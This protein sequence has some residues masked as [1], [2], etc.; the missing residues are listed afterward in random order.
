MA[1]PPPPPPLDNMFPQYSLGIEGLP[2]INANKA[3]QI[4]GSR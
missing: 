1:N 4:V 3:S 2:T